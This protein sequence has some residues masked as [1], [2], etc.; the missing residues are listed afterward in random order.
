MISTEPD[1][2]LTKAPEDV[3]VWYLYP[4]AVVIVPPV[5]TKLRAIT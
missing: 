3:N 5:P 2:L 4:P 1:V